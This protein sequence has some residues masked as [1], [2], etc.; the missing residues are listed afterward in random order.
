MEPITLILTALLAGAAK[1]A[2]QAAAN[3][4]QDAYRGFRDALKH[5]LAGKPAAQQAVEEY[6]ADPGAW[7]GNLEVHLKQ[8]GAD[9]D[10][11]V[12][13]SASSVMRLADPPG[14]ST[15]KYVVN[16]SGGQGFQVGDNN[17]QT[18]TF[19]AA[20]DRSAT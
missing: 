5:R 7:E 18:N 6:I 17:Q 8:A 19:Y 3:A 20:P 14:A 11:A 15:G 2:G 4:V 10:Q 12:L 13:D 16:I 9:K 1:G